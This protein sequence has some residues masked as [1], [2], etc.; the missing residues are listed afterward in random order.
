MKG[1][2]AIKLNGV[3]RVLPLG[4]IGAAMLEYAR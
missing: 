1:S 3:D 4:S 2:S